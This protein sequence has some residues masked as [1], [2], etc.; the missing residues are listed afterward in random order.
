MTQGE[1]DEL[2]RW[3]VLQAVELEDGCADLFLQHGTYYLD[4]PE[5]YGRERGVEPGRHR[6]PV[7]VQRLLKWERI[8]GAN[9]VRR[10]IKSA[11]E[12]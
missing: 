6:L 11:L 9:E 10:A 2:K 5:D 3:S 8:A 12:I 1:R 4:V 7:Q